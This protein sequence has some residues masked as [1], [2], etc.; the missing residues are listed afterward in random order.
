MVL[1]GGSSARGLARRVTSVVLLGGY[2]CG[3]ARFVCLWSC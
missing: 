2:V 1:L 3:F